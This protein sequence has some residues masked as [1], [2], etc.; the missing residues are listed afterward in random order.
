MWF[1]WLVAVVWVVSG[2]LMFGMCKGAR[3][4]YYEYFEHIG[5]TKEAERDCWKFAFSGLAGL[6]LFCYLGNVY[7]H[8][9]GYVDGFHF[10]LFM[11]KEL[12]APRAVRV[13]QEK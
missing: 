11:P 1:L 12:W 4:A 7:R 3:R 5:H 8:F 13:R 2:F 6:I 9:P 10:C